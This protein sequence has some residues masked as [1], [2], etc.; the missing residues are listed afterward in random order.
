MLQCLSNESEPHLGIAHGTVTD[1]ES[2]TREENLA[3]G[4]GDTRAHYAADLAARG[5]AT[6]WTPPRNTPCW[7]GSTHQGDCKVV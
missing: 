2:F 7:C 4:D 1:F 3:P 6:P 5:Q